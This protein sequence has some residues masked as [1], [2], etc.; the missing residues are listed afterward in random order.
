MCKIPWI[1]F[2]LKSWRTFCRARESREEEIVM[3][4]AVR[5]A[6]FVFN[7][8]VSWSVN[9]CDCL[10]CPTSQYINK[11][12]YQ[13][14]LIYILQTPPQFWML[15]YRIANIVLILQK[16]LN[17]NQMKR[18]MGCSSFFR[19]GRT[20]LNDVKAWNTVEKQ[21]SGKRDYFM[22]VFPA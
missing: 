17:A 18:M 2:L 10:L 15:I 9:I 4:P 6:A 12:I 3:N 22:D 14:L 21:N 7:I 5:D 8:T 13:F 1:I 11:I 16:F 19:R 20:C